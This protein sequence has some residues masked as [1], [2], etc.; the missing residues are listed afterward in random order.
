MNRKLLVTIITVFSLNLLFAQTSPDGE[1][2]IYTRETHLSSINYFSSSFELPSI[3]NS[4]RFYLYGLSYNYDYD[5]ANLGNI[6]IGTEDEFRF[7]LKGTFRIGASIGK[8][9]LQDSRGL[10]PSNNLKYY[11]ITADFFSIAVCP[12]YTHILQDGYSFTIELG[13]GLLNIGGDALILEGGS[14]QKHAIGIIKVV[15]FVFKPAVFFDFGRSGVGIG[16]YINPLDIF[17]ILISS[18]EL[19]E[20]KR[21]ISS[22]NSFYKR[23]ELQ[24]IFTF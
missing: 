6:S 18:D 5:I 21:G 19:Y 8:K 24:I 11:G 23:F 9:T 10:Y 3:I 1:I 17:N 12:Q 20:G 15:P 16:G 2:E 7:T 13:I 22:G 4:D 14:L